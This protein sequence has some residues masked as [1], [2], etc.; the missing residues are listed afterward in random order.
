MTYGSPLSYVPIAS[1]AIA[2]GGLAVR[3]LW[4]DGTAKKHLIAACLFFLLV[5]SGALWWQ[6]HDDEV[7][8]R[9]AADELVAIMGNETRTYDE[10]VSGLRLPDYRVVN[11]AI[12]LLIREQ[13]IGSEGAT[14]I[15]KSDDRPRLVRLY[16]VRTF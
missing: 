9:R 6:Q 5:A 12:E 10:I 16:F 1:F 7:R 13:R 2:A 3:M 15:D 11:A 14:I 8:V 4:P